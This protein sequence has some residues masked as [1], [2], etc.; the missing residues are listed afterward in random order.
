MRL[1]P[2]RSQPSGQ[3]DARTI[4]P[5][6]F[7]PV[8]CS[9][10][11]PA[12]RC[13][14][15]RA[16]SGEFVQEGRVRR[17]PRREPEV[18]LGNSPSNP[19]RVQPNGQRTERA[20]RC[21][22][23]KTYRQEPRVFIAI[24][25]LILLPFAVSPLGVSPPACSGLGVTRAQTASVEASEREDAAPHSCL[26]GMLYEGQVAKTPVA[27]P[28]TPRSS[29]NGDAAKKVRH[30]ALVVAASIVERLATATEEHEA[31]LQHEQFR[32]ALPYFG[33]CQSAAR[34]MVGDEEAVPIEVD[35]F[36]NNL[37]EVL[38]ALDAVPSAITAIPVRAAKALR[39]EL[40]AVK[41]Q[42]NGVVELQDVSLAT[43][44]AATSAQ[45]AVAL[46]QRV[47]RRVDVVLYGRGLTQITGVAR[48]FTNKELRPALQELKACI[49]AMV[50]SEGERVLQVDSK[51]RP[52]D[53]QLA[54]VEAA[55]EQVEV[56]AD[57]LCNV[58]A[59]EP[60]RERVGMVLTDLEKLRKNL[61]KP[62]ALASKP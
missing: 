50:N 18:F 51:G 26:I 7:E 35:H 19:S 38:R 9:T 34:R 59:V 12:H 29:R 36:H 10:R 30:S 54:R 62:K 3:S 16:A 23:P 57:V 47:F 45:D 25:S 6:H 17:R 2:S 56:G 5:L 4:G 61:A 32:V 33:A 24:A 60:L 53:R 21:T 8:G 27:G 58:H 28:S 1:S 42:A 52:L 44:S 40:G 20:T 55:F 43:L 15:R 46:A 39:K 11:S 37:D 31:V 13:R 14:R 48:E 22:F 49:E 41:A